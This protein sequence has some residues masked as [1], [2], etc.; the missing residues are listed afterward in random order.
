MRV[1]G[2]MVVDR[3]TEMNKAIEITSAKADLAAHNVLVLRLTIDNLETRRDRIGVEQEAEEAAIE[4]LKEN[5]ERMIREREAR[6]LTGRNWLQRL[7]RS[8]VLQAFPS[9]RNGV[10]RNLQMRAILERDR[11]TFPE[12]GLPTSAYLPT[13]EENKE[14]EEEQVEMQRQMKD[15]LKE[16]EGR[17]SELLANWVEEDTNMKCL[18]QLLAQ[19]FH[20]QWVSL[21]EQRNREVLRRNEIAGNF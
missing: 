7:W 2:Q 9:Q 10:Q 14:Q 16:R 5:L 8:A 6:M 20:P 4:D 13:Y 18:T 19:H 11:P 12:L 15:E 17:E 21:V 1:R 3:I